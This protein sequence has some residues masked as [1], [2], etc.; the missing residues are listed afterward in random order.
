MV[1]HDTMQPQALALVV[2][3]PVLSTIF[4]ALRV[5]IRVTM[6]QFHWGAYSISLI[7]Q[8]HLLTYATPTD[9]GLCVVACVL[10][11]AYAGVVYHWIQYQWF[12]FHV[13][14]IPDYVRAVDNQVFA[15]KLNM[16][17]QMLYN[18]ILGIV[19]A[20]IILF[21]LRLGDRR[22]FIRYGL[23]AFFIFK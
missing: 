16:A 17:Q 3:F 22:W 6:Q 12:G 5:W 23:I 18:P 9:D 10:A 1:A 8:S 19:K 15:S 4:V 7:F 13:W 14:D 11:V 2:L 21:L 20:S